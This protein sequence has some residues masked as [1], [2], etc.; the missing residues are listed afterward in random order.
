[1]VRQI[2]V[3]LDPEAVARAE[4]DSGSPVNAPVPAAQ[5]RISLDASWDLKFA[6]ALAGKVRVARRDGDLRIPGDPPIPLGLRTLVLEANA[7][8]TGGQA[9]RLDARLDMATARMG[10]ING[11]A[12]ATLGGLALDPRQ[13]IRVALDADVTDLAWLGLF[14]GDTLEVGGM[15]KANVRAQG[16]L[17]GKWNASGTVNGDKLRVV[18]IDDGVRLIDGMLRARLQDDRVILDSLRFPASLRVMPAE[19]RTREWVS[20]NPDAKGGYL[21]PPAN[22]SCRPRAARCGCNCIASRRCSARTATAWCPAW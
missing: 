8:P 9:S 12:S 14:V 22:G 15:L 4:R 11:T 13:P 20:T 2:L 10:A 16:S 5:R 19:W 17:D 21:E 7:T 6:G 1:M 3:A 18:R